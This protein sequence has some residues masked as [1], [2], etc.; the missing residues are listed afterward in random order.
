MATGKTW[1]AIKANGSG[2]Q[3]EK[4]EVL[5]ET[6]PIKGKSSQRRVGLLEKDGVSPLIPGEYFIHGGDCRNAT[7][8]SAPVCMGNPKGSQPDYRSTAYQTA[9]RTLESGDS[10]K[11]KGL[12]CPLKSEQRSASLKISLKH[13]SAGIA[14]KHA[15]GY[16]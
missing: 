13:S 12:K 11:A 15:P 9:W 4:E 8:F 1:E 10:A 2:K 7:S 14:G 16:A 3:Q 5:G 6:E